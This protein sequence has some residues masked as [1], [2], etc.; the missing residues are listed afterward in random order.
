MHSIRRVLPFLGLCASVP[1]ANTVCLLVCLV[2]T[3]NKKCKDGIN[4]RIKKGVNWKS[5]TWSKPLWKQPKHLTN[6]TF[7]FRRIFKFLILPCRIALLWQHATQVCICVSCATCF[8]I[9]S[10]ASALERYRLRRRNL[11]ATVCA[12]QNLPKSL[13]FVTSPYVHWEWAIQPKNAIT[14]AG[15]IR[16]T[17]AR[18]RPRLELLPSDLLYKRLG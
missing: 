6:I 7:C 4:Q 17:S 8:S 14:S 16:S 1:F 2:Q 13:N 11:V 15:L 12:C 9:N 5:K 18:M 10:A 3:C